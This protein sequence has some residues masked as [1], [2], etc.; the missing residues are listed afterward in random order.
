MCVCCNVDYAIGHHGG[1][2]NR[3]RET[4]L[5]ENLKFSIGRQHDEVS[6]AR[7]LDKQYLAGITAEG[8]RFRSYL[9]TVFKH[10]LSNEWKK[11][12]TQKR[13]GRQTIVSLDWQAAESRYQDEPVDHQ[14]PEKVFDR[15]WASSL[16]DR[17]LVAVQ[18]EYTA[19]GRADV[20]QALRGSLSG[21]T[22]RI[23]YAVLGDGLKVSEGAVKIAVHRL[24]KRYGE[25][26]RAEIATTV[27]HAEDVDE[28]IR[29]LISLVG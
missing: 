17:V 6:V 9:L 5:A 23:P 21:D 15:H 12:Q 20:F 26:L 16:L 29:Y 18:F 1:A 3:R 25:L 11:S 22:A 24:R 19:N 28:E 8:G 14:T 2:V 27:S 7:L 4:G 10:F 13:G